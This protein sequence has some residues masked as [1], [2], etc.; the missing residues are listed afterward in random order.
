MRLLPLVLLMATLVPAARAEPTPPASER[1]KMSYSLGHQVGA[2]YRKQMLELDPEMFRRGLQD[3]LTDNPS[4][5][6]EADM[7]RLR[8]E[9]RRLAQEAQ[10]RQAEAES[11][12]RRTAG[13]QFMAENGRQPGVITL[14]SGL[15]YRV[16][17]EGSGPKPGPRDQVTVHY[18]GTLLDGSEFDSS[19]RRQQPATFPLNGVI[20]GWTEGLQL[21]G[22]GAR[23]QFAIP[24]DLAYGNRG[25]L[26]DQ[27][28]L[29]EVELIAV[30]PAAAPPAN[31]AR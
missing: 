25:R 19:H 2:G 20:P 22:E 11:E 6:T 27:T 29:F 31:P 26:A 24:P 9:A 30:L 8:N 16:L 23:Y 3:G 4:P 1:E 10:R 14:A 5:L 18:R 28:L 13:R 7:N 12:S 21:M 17:R 15:Q